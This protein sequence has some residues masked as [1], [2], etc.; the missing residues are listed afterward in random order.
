MVV[1]FFQL[2]YSHRIPVE[3]KKSENVCGKFPSS[4]HIDLPIAGDLVDG[5][6]C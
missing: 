6:N 2:W 1:T 3:T 5:T 4:I